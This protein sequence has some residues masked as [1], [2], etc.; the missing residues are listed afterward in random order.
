MTRRPPRATLSRPSGS[1]HDEDQARIRRRHRGAN[2]RVR[3]APGNARVPAPCRDRDR[4]RDSPRA[5]DAH[6]GHGPARSGEVTL[7]APPL[8]AARGGARRE[9]RTA[10]PALHRAVLRRRREPSDLRR[11]DRDTRQ[12]AQRRASR[13]RRCDESHRQKP[14]G[15]GRRRAEPR[16]PGGLRAHHRIRRRCPRSAGVAPRRRAIGDHSEADESIYERMR[17]QPFEPPQE[18]FL[19]LVNGPD[20]ANEIDRI[21]AAVEAAS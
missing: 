10:Q 14:R 8:R 9:R 11:G 21:V 2:A 1:E 4:A 18:G 20:L 12:S 19:E 6:R 15:D 17:A 13:R 3:D 16:G 5:A 7:R